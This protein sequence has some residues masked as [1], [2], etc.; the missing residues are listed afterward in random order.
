[1]ELSSSKIKVFLIFSEIELS[2]PKLIK[3]LYFRWELEKPEKQ[4]KNLL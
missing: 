1:M 3:L 2:S 4:T